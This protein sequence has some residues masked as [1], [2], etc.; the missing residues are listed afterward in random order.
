MGALALPLCGYRLAYGAMADP[1]SDREPHDFAAFRT[2]LRAL[3]TR[4][5]AECLWDLKEEPD[6]EQE[7]VARMVLRRI[8]SCGDRIG[9][10]EAQRLLR[11]LSRTSSAP[12]ARS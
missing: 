6:L 8:V 3:V 2:R 7:A 4:Y 12:S 5:G 10:V 1:V 9:F 11:W